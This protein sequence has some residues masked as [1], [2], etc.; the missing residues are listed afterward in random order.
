MLNFQ[1]K[2]SSR[3]E[4]RNMVIILTE[5]QSFLWS[6]RRMLFHRKYTIF[7][8]WEINKR[9]RT[10]L[11]R[12]N[13]LFKGR[14]SDQCPVIDTVFSMRAFSLSTFWLFWLCF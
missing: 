13:E 3:Y 14:Y 9:F 7:N 12:E 4:S 2:T 5:F 10:H 6:F 1:E 8:L 11:I